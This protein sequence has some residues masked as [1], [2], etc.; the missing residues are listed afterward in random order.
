MAI[1]VK[2]KPELDLSSSM[3]PTI[4]KN[5][6]EIKKKKTD[7]EE[8][9]TNLLVRIPVLERSPRRWEFILDG[10]KIMASITDE[11]FFDRLESGKV[12]IKKG[13]EFRVSLRIYGKGKRKRYEV[14]KFL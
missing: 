10:R 4:V 7:H 8:I 11:D 9:I 6:D 2:K 3:F 13:D 12:A 14:I 1:R 5:A